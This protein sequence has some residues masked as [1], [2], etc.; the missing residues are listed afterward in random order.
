MKIALA[1]Y[2]PYWKLYYQKEQNR[3]LTQLQ[4]SKLTARVEHI[5]STSIVGLAAKPTIDILIGIPAHLELDSYISALQKQG[6]IYVSKYNESLPLRRF[7][8]K[9]K[10][11]ALW[12]KTQ[13][14]EIKKEG[15]MPLRSSFER[16]FHIHL[17]HANTAFYQ[18]HIAFRNHLRKSEKD[19]EFY[20][21]L[22]IHLSRQDWAKEGDY[23]QAKAPFI[24]G[25]LQNINKI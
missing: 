9:I 20:Q 16:L 11:M 17:V 14:K 7:F 25:I 10:P 21:N 13:G 18:E 19:R 22:K 4:K 5:G 3:I 23:A 6:Y 12:D 8:I 15:K 2:S 24:Q 1:A